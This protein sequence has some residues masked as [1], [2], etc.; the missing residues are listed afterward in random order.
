MILYHGSNMLIEDIDLDKSFHIFQPI[1]KLSFI[2]TAV[3]EF[4]NLQTYFI[5]GNRTINNIILFN[6][7]L[8]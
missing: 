7:I 6:I 3:F 1:Q 4:T 8:G 2:N 5:I